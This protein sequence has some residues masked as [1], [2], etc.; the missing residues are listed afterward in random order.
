MRMLIGILLLLPGFVLAAN[1]MSRALDAFNRADYSLAQQTWEYVANQG[2]TAAQY[3]LA[4]L[5][6][7]GIGVDVN[8]EKSL[9]M[10]RIA[11]HGDLVDAYNS[12]LENAVQPASREDSLQAIAVTDPQIW[13]K[14]Q[15]GKHY[16]LQLASSRSQELIE[17][18][19]A[20][21]ELAGKA[22]YYK[23]KRQ[24]ELWFALVYGSYE[25]VSDANEAIA[26][27]PKDLRK[28]SPWVRRIDSI[29]KI[30][31]P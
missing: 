4:Y 3:N 22:G 7:N 9:R 13:I 2:D 12:L 15:D 23:S 24:G 16:T 31:V 26:E 27:L 29:H 10:V 17:K 14:T 6:H 28:W 30:T 18:Y 25:S 20:E 11:A 5:Y 21:N 1:E 8:E 19:F